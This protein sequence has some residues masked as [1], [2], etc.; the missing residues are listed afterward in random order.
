MDYLDGKRIFDAFSAG[1]R[2]VIDH[3]DILNRINV[4]PVPDGDTGTNLAA[5]LSHMIETTKVTD[6]ATE[7]MTSMS[8]AALEGARGNSGAIFAQFI[9]GLREAIEGLPLLT[10]EHF[11]RAVSSA[12]DRAWEAV[13]APREGTILS[14]IHEWS[15]SLSHYARDTRTFKELFDRTLPSLEDSL[16]RTPEQLPVLKHAGVVDAG[17]QGFFHFVRGALDFLT[18]GTAPTAGTPATIDLDSSH[19]LPDAEDTLTFRYCLEVMLA[20]TGSTPAALRKDLEPYGDSLIVVH[21]PRRSRIHIHTDRPAEIV[22]TLRCHGRILSQKADD[23][24]DQFQTVHHRKHSIALVTDSSCDLPREVLDEHQVHVIPLRILCNNTE[25]IDRVT[26]TPELF[27]RHQKAAV[28]PPTTSQPP[29]AELHRMFAW[30]STHYTSI[31]AIHVAGKM[32]G[33]FAASARE[34][35]RIAGARITVIDS[36]HL[37]GSLG[38]IVLRAAQAVQDGASHDE[39]VRLVES[40]RSRSRILVSVP[41][42]DFMVRGGRVSPV[43]GFAARLLN[44]TPIVSVDHEGTSVLYGKAFGMRSNIRK[45]I[46]SVARHHREH[47]LRCYAVVHAG[48]EEAARQLAARLKTVLGKDPSYIMEISPVVSLNSGPGA[49]SVVTMDE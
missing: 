16:R 5:T 26:I 36:R 24:R 47:P 31:I 11:A 6:S 48:A 23:M 38:L 27:A 9:G 29:A 19:D 32:S 25:Y 2:H 1:A 40:L 28:I 44:L 14:V 7:T 42:L 43:T 30:L 22:E 15:R 39:V 33:T 13:S 3:Q 34:A 45:I 18:T 37:S 10:T 17:A 8:D 21:T 46:E 35:Q 20:E 12:R 4:F 49:L 41:T